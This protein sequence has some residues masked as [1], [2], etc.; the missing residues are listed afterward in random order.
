MEEGGGGGGGISNGSIYYT[1]NH[2]TLSF[3]L[4]HSLIVHAGY[5]QPLS[6]SQL[7]VAGGVAS[8]CETSSPFQFQPVHPTLRTTA[9]EAELT[10][11][12]YIALPIYT[13]LFQHTVSM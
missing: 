12:I 2:F 5:M 13:C 11:C 4:I 1:Y 9:G 3:P 10:Q 7:S 8:L 6:K